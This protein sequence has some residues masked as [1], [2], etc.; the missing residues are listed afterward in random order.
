MVSSGR[1]SLTPET[2]SERAAAKLVQKVRMRSACL[3][4]FMRLAR[5]VSRPAVL[6][7]AECGNTSPCRGLPASFEPRA[8]ARLA[9]LAKAVGLKHAKAR[10]G[11]I[12]TTNPAVKRPV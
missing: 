12:V 5:R 10:F 7:L 6:R 1:D 9:V 2:P 3:A 8:L 4:A 11:L